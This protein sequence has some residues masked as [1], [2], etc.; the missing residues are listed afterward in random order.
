MC[1]LVALPATVAMTVNQDLCSDRQTEHQTRR[2]CASKI[3]LELAGHLACGPHLAAEP[4]VDF[5]VAAAD[6]WL[7]GPPENEAIR[8]RLHYGRTVAESL[9]CTICIL[10]ICCCN[11]SDMNPGTACVIYWTNGCDGFCKNWKCC[12]AFGP[13]AARAAALFGFGI[14]D[15]PET[16]L[17]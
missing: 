12:I 6:F 14:V 10:C 13:S 4:P 15:G 7:A 3:Y 11:G 1:A 5:A 9:T 17:G 16:A 2:Y 8:L